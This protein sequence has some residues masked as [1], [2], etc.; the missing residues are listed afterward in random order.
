M[1]EAVTDALGTAEGDAPAPDVMMPLSKAE[2]I[3][4]V[5]V[6]SSSLCVYVGRVCVTSKREKGG[7]RKR[8]P[9]ECE[10]AGVRE[11]GST[12]TCPI[13]TWHL[14]HRHVQGAMLAAEI[15]R[16]EH[17]EVHRCF[18]PADELRRVQDR[19]IATLVSS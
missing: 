1:V 13:T 5:R 18:L 3:L 9:C 14:S 12:T 2:S 8:E 10:C 17:S 7:E 19:V 11:G 15:A 6:V 4:R 16:V